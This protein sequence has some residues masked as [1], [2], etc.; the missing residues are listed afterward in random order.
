MA[1]TAIILCRKE[2]TRLKAKHF[3]KIGNKHLINYTI[4]S[5]KKINFINEIYIATGGKAK[6]Y[7]F[8][9]KLK[10]KYPEL[11]FYFH[12]NENR[13]VERLY[14]LSKKITN[15]KLLIIS[16]DCPII[17]NIFVN[18]MI[19]NF[20]KEDFDFSYS[21]IKLQHEGILLCKKKIWKKI[22]QR[23]DNDVLQEHPSL[24]LKKNLI[25]FNYLVTPFK[26]IDLYKGFRMSVDTQSD[27]D[28]FNI[29]YLI[30]KK[31]KLEFNY[32][33][34]I[35]NVK[36]KE[37][38]S[39]VNQKNENF[40]KSLN[41]LI[42][43][44]KNKKFGLGHYHRA[45]TLKREIVERLSIVPKIILIK[46][47]KTCMKIKKNIYINQN[48]LSA[49][50]IFDLP[51]LYFKFFDNLN[52]KNNKNI[53][54]DNYSRNSQNYTLIPSLVHNEKTIIKKKQNLILD[55]KIN[56][57]YYLWKLNKK[58]YLYDFLVIM[59][60]TFQIKNKMLHDLIKLNKDRK[61]IFILGPFVK[62]TTKAFLKNLGFNYFV[63]PKNYFDIML[64]SKNIIS[65]F[66][67]SVYE[68]IYLNIKP[69]IY[70][71]NDNSQR[72]KDIKKLI[73]FGFANNYN[74]KKLVKFKN[75]NPII[76]KKN[77]NLGA[78]KIVNI[79]NNI[80]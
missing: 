36:Y 47:L 4:D 41:I 46:N 27:L 66:G 30:C 40:N 39:H 22:N 45:H 35:K 71:C 24:Y 61:I 76:L 6:N 25:N 20:N 59:G 32:E 12:K 5:L 42:V 62:N 8:K 56:F 38:N 37:I 7:I 9:E 64:R 21:K 65:R 75:E 17:D 58:N 52:Y 73:K 51:D 3:K 63:N 13:V 1:I 11:K 43:T 57:S 26:K 33:N 16:G 54:V 48:N 72:R 50:Y 78:R 10:N 23:C 19:L 60:G 69:W 55:R 70:F 18:N 77:I 67:V 44:V 49:I 79:I 15:Q 2:S 53:I 29:N 80:Q 31:K 28:F 34:L 74:I 68:A 14:F